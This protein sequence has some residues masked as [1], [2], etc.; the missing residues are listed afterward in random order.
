MKDKARETWNAIKYRVLMAV[1]LL[2][3]VGVIVGEGLV[4]GLRF[5]WR[6][7]KSKAGEI[8]AAL[9]LLKGGENERNGNE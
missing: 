2:V 8:R 5:L 3:A 9:K 1:L 7:T 6:K 4:V